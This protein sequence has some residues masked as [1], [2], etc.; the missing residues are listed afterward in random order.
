MKIFITALSDLSLSKGNVTHILEVVGQL[1]RMGHDITLFVPKYGL[2][3]GELPFRVV[4]V[5]LV[6]I[7]VRGLRFFSDLISFQIALFFCLIRLCLKQKPDAIYSRHD[8]FIVAPSVLAGIFHIPL[9]SEVNGVFSDE[10]SFRGHGIAGIWI[11][12]LIERFAYKCSKR[13]IV[14]TEGI[15]EHLTNALGIEREKISVISNG[16]DIELVKPQDPG[17]AKQRLGISSTSYVIGYLGNFEYYQGIEYLIRGL[18]DVLKKYPGVCCLL[19]GD[20][21]LKPTIETLTKELG[22]FDS[23]VFTGAVPHSKVGEYL[24]A[25]D[26]CVAPKIPIKS[27]YSPL[28]LY[29]YLSA[30]RPVITSDTSGFEL[31]VEYQCG[32]LAK[33]KDPES[34]TEKIIELLENLEKRLEM[35]KNARLYMEKFGGWEKVIS[36]VEA[37]IQ[38]EIEHRSE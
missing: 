2:Y 20:G 38:K 5:P 14:V 7:P 35:G 26:V 23:C 13:V 29:E 32:L 25:M 9:F 36:K 11:N 34:M 19:V 33:P 8:V 17:P 37:V 30:G 4:Y 22:V 16:A 28:K 3:K 15:K 10:L 18:P 12:N 21:S 6:Q 31:L 24:A 27:G 1:T